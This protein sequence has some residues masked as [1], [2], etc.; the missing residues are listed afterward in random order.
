MGFDSGYLDQDVSFNQLLNWIAIYGESNTTRPDVTLFEGPQPAL[1]DPHSMNLQQP[2]QNH[3][4][5]LQPLYG[6]EGDDYLADM[7]IGDQGPICPP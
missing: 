6:L 3:T 5:P 1:L 4:L 7:S 2:Y